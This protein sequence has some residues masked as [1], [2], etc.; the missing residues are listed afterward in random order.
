MPLVAG[1]EPGIDDAIVSGELG[2]VDG[3]AARFEVSRRGGGNAARRADPSGD[4]AGSDDF[5]D[6]DGQIDALGDQ[7]DEVVGHHQLDLD[8][9]MQFQKNS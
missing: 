3:L 5:A 4:Q 2:G 1:G 7:I 6:P 9:G 8:V